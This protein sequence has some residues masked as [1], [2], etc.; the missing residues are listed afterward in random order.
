[1]PRPLFGKPQAERTRTI[2][3]VNFERYNPPAAAVSSALRKNAANEPLKWVRLQV[4]WHRDQDV[5]DLPR[6]VRCLWPMLLGLAGTN[7]PHGT[8]RTS[9][10]KL[11]RDGDLDEGEVT[12]AL[13]FLWK[14]GRI[15]YS[16]PSKRHPRAIPPAGY[17]P[18]Y[19][20]TDEQTSRAREDEIKK[21]ERLRDDAVD[22][23]MKATLQRKIDRLVGKVA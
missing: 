15:R 20:R 3:I 12:S 11:A 14:R 18:T 7:V 21:L 6:S 22:E 9:V 13:R 16:T 1:M 8:V 10:Q 5:L 17:V 23:V 19:P 2:V 4:D